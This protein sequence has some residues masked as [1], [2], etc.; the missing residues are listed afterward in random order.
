M[1]TW[2]AIVAV[3]KFRG[4]LDS[5][6]NRRQSRKSSVVSGLLTADEDPEMKKISRLEQYPIFRKDRCLFF[7]A[8]DNNG[9]TEA[10]SSRALQRIPAADENE[11]MWVN[12]PSK[13]FSFIGKLIF[14]SL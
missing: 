14:Q 12:S 4:R 9:K 3:R 8:V 7:K 5:S 2:K 11:L 6:R 13:L 10:E 1:A